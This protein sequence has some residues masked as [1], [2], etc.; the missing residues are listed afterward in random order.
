MNYLD[1]KEKLNVVTA[2]GDIKKL[3]KEIKKDHSFAKSLIDDQTI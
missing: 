3:A 1:V 2:K